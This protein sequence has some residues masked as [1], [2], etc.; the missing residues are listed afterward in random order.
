MK[1][2][3]GDCLSVMQ[4]NEFKELVQGKM[5]VIVTDPPF[6]INYHYKNY[7]D[8]MK[9]ADYYSF[10]KKVLIYPSAVVHYPEAICRLSIELGYAPTR[11]VSWVYNSNTARQHRDIAFFGINP[12]FRKVKQP[13]KNPKDKRIAERIAQGKGAR[14]YDWWEIN[15]VKNVSK[16][17]GG[18][19]HPCIMP[20]EVLKRVI[21]ILPE[22]CVIIDPFM[23]SGT[24]GVAC[25]EL[26]KDFIGIELDEAY[27]EEA[28]RRIYGH[29]HN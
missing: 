2:F 17:R 11:V 3:Q 19:S 14:L 23:G 16:S 10:L 12:D 21:G 6:N 29:Q 8:K 5:A 20:L 22:D 1:L 28:E 25:K 24:T 15:Q 18:Y 27:F 13:Y 4:E 9:E 26:G 7:K